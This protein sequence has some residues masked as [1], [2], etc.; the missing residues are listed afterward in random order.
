MYHFEWWYTYDSLFHKPPLFRCSKCYQGAVSLPADV[1][2]CPYLII[3]LKYSSW[4]SLLPRGRGWEKHRPGGKVSVCVATTH[5]TRKR[6][7]L[8]CSYPENPRETAARSSALTWRIPGTGEP[9]GLQSMGSHRVG[10]DWSD[11][12][13]AAAAIIYRLDKQQ[14][15]V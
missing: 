11:L 13:A 14:G 12:A 8:Q 2:L 6:H 9:G 15:S 5:R 4:H 3:F 1:F 10:H 7:P